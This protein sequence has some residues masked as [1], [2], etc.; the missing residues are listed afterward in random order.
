MESPSPRPLTNSI[1][2]FMLRT[3]KLDPS[4]HQTRIP[5]AEQFLFHAKLCNVMEE[6]NQLIAHHDSSFQLFDF[7]MLSGMSHEELSSLYRR[8]M[9][10]KVDGPP[11]TPRSPTKKKPKKVLGTTEPSVQENTP[12]PGILKML[13]DCSDDLMVEGRFCGG[14]WFDLDRPEVTVFSSYRHRQFIVCFR[15]S[16][17]QQLKPA[18]LK[19]EKQ[20]KIESTHL[21][22]D[23]SDVHV[24]KYM[25][26]AY[27]TGDMEEKVF[28]LL[29]QLSERDPFC[30]VVM[31]GHS[32]GGALAC[33]SAVRFATRYPIMTVSCHAFGSPKVGEKSFQDWADTLPNLKIM[34]LEHGSDPF[35]K[36]P[37]DT[38]W[39]NVGHSIVFVEEQSTAEGAPLSSETVCSPK[40]GE[41]AK[42]AITVHAYKFDDRKP[43][44][45]ISWSGANGLNAQKMKKMKK[46]HEL[47]SYINCLELFT[48]SSDLQWVS[49]YVG[50]EGKG[51]SGLDNEERCIV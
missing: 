34:R 27:Q 10:E 49:H 33:L 37:D 7:N 2:Q 50:Q 6:Y 35:V 48:K 41:T 17:R 20:K 21:H 24:N 19:P 14:K 39:T 42:S 43:F 18:S 8:I 13:L 9:G 38:K 29:N 30:D 40:S 1:F 11:A 45:P 22:S 47:C 12:N 36:T 5:P 46:D 28:D 31:C 4:V 51:I 16:M 32:F 44:K 26:D 15:G 25:A 23:L 3:S